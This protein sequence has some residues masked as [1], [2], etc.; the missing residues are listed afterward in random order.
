[1][2]IVGIRY[3]VGGKVVQHRDGQIT[4]TTPTGH[5]Y[6]SNPYDYRVAD[7]SDPIFDYV[8]RLALREARPPDPP[9][10]ATDT[11]ADDEPPF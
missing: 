2:C 11:G 5:S 3:V 10:P 1:M 9:P 4:W 6:T 8:K 7:D